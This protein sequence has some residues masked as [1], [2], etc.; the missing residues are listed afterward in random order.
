MLSLVRV[1][2]KHKLK[3]N[4]ASFD[5]FL[6]FCLTFLPD[7]QLN[8]MRVFIA[9]TE[10]ASHSEENEN[11]H[12]NGND[13]SSAA[14]V[15]SSEAAEC[16][17]K[18]S[19]SQ[20]QQLIDTFLCLIECLDYMVAHVAANTAQAYLKA[21]SLSS[22][23]D[24]IAFYFRFNSVLSL[25]FKFKLAVNLE[26]I[27]LRFA[28][29]IQRFLFKLLINKPFDQVAALTE[30]S[31]DKEHQHSFL[32][33]YF[34]MLFAFVEQNNV[35]AYGYYLKSGYLEATHQFW[36]DLNMT[37]KRSV[38]L[39]E[40]LIKNLVKCLV[41]NCYFKR[42]YLDPELP[43]HEKHDSCFSHLK[44]LYFFES[45]YS[46]VISKISQLK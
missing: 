46:T 11:D 13:N 21:N 9:S 34:S 42:D 6:R 25:R 18:S 28:R 10:E 38:C 43:I 40:Y 22:L 29:Y 19:T 41:I 36:T 44:N 20:Q 26:L 14:S 5:T 27:V 32:V 39:N 16:E 33:S 17:Q 4:K 1:V 31:E 30:N 8:Q 12:D 7:A 23:F 15:A 24:C 35:N 45:Q 3:L 37:L 2:L